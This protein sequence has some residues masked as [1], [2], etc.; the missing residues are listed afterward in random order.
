MRIQ[1]N[2]LII[3]SYSASFTLDNKYYQTLTIHTSIIHSIIFKAW[4][5]S[6]HALAMTR[7]TV[8]TGQ[9]AMTKKK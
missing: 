9:V 7:E 5:A 2:S 3:F 4:I 8:I 1:I 6:A